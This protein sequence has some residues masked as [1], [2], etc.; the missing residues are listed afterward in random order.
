VGTLNTLHQVGLDTFNKL[1][2][3]LPISLKLELAT[4]SQFPPN[5][6]AVTAPLPWDSDRKQEAL[7]YKDPAEVH[8]LVCSH[9][10]S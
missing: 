1:Y 8:L 3:K 10:Q 7:R 4:S 6:A 2:L 9:R 5:L